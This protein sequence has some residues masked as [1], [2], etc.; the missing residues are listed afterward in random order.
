M[1]R[2]SNEFSGVSSGA[3]NERDCNGDIAAAAAVAAVAVAAAAA[4]FQTETHWSSWASRGSRFVPACEIL[5]K[6]RVHWD[7]AQKWNLSLLAK[8]F[9]ESILLTILFSLPCKNW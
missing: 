5:V 6:R 3:S 1:F 4:E 2:R 7:E 9:W 8:H